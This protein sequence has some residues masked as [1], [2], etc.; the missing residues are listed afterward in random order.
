MNRKFIDNYLNN[1]ENFYIERIFPEGDFFDA[2][3]LDKNSRIEITY[4]IELTEYNKKIMYLF[5]KFPYPDIIR[6]II[7]K[8]KFTQ[9]Q[10]Q[11]ILNNIFQD[12]EITLEKH[13]LDILIEDISELCTNS[14]YIQNFQA[15]FLRNQLYSH[16][17]TEASSSLNNYYSDDD[18]YHTEGDG[19]ETD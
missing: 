10:E 5:K 2:H 17:S 3:Y 18:S 11:I 9:F 14:R 7:K 16:Y 4:T 6:I 13:L 19:N 1:I 15:N 12:L 8:L